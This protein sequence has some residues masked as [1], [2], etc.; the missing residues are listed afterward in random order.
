MMTMTGMRW[1]AGARFSFGMNTQLKRR[2]E[3]EKVTLDD[4]DEEL[5]WVC[6]KCKSPT[7]GGRWNCQACGAEAGGISEGGAFTSPRGIVV[8]TM[9]NTWAV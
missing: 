5:V 4:P 1:E 7:V 9:E 3:W 8:V 2:T 6:G